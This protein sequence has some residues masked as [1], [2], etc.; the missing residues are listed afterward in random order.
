MIEHCLEYREPGWKGQ[1]V[2][3]SVNQNDVKKATGCIGRN[4]GNNALNRQAFDLSYVFEVADPI[5]RNIHPYD[6]MPLSRDKKSIAALSTPHV[7]DP[8]ILPIELAKELDEN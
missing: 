6:A 7:Q 4:I 1:H 2:Q 8:K 5:G 3:R